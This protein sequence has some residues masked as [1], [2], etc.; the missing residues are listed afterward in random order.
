MVGFVRTEESVYH[1]HRGLSRARRNRE[2]I[3]WARTKKD[4]IWARSRE[5][6]QYNAVPLKA[7]GAKL[8]FFDREGTWNVLLLRNKEGTEKSRNTKTIDPNP[9]YVWA[10]R[11]DSITRNSLA[12]QYNT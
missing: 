5:G 12:T 8:L 3:F 11:E 9:G 6:T 2:R 7:A 10:E 1:V 4:P